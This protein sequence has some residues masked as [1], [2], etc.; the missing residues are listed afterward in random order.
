MIEIIGWL[1]V[2]LG[3]CV[4]PPQLY[5]IIKTGKTEAISLPTYTFLCMALACYLIY[6]IYIQDPVFITAQSI[7]LGINTMILIKLLR[8]KNVSI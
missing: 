7:N 3:L 2:A 8:V 5:K 1:G 4:A 6:A